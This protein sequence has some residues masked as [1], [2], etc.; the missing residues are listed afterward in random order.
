MNPRGERN[1]LFR[2]RIAVWQRSKTERWAAALHGIP[3]TRQAGAA[4]CE[5]CL[6]LL[7]EQEQHSDSIYD[8]ADFFSHDAKALEYQGLQYQ[9]DEYL[10]RW[11]RPDTVLF[12]VRVFLGTRHSPVSEKHSWA[13]G[14]STSRL[15]P[16]QGCSMLK[17]WATSAPS[18]RRSAALSSRTSG[19]SPHPSLLRIHNRKETEG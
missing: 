17:R 3:E 11:V 13:F 5:N 16:P 2:L 9:P 19:P 18:S 4:A 14:R 7:P 12:P 8:F 6:F 10:A 1:A 15:G